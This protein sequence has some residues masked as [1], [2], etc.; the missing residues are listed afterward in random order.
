MILPAKS[1]EV[2]RL[3]L[4]RG[5]CLQTQKGAFS[6]TFLKILS[7]CFIQQGYQLFAELRLHLT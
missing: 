3:V 1:P 7:S 2:L 4:T 5:P 6:S